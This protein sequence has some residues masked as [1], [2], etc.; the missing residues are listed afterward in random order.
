MAEKSLQAPWP[1]KLQQLRWR[2]VEE[3]DVEGELLGSQLRAEATRQAG[4]GSLFL[5]HRVDWF[6][7]HATRVRDVMEA[8]HWPT[9]GLW[10]SAGW[11]VALSLGYGLTELGES[12]LMNLLSVP[13]VGIV[14]WNV[15]VTI[16]SLFLEWKATPKKPAMPMWLRGVVKRWLPAGGD[17]LAAK[18]IGRFRSMSEPLV[19]LRVSSRARAWLHIAAALLALGTITGMYAK[20]WSK[21]Y[22]AVWESTLLDAPTAKAFLSALHGPTAKI[23]G[24]PLPLENFDAMRAGPGREPHPGDALPWIH[25]YAGTLLLLVLLP[26]LGL[27]AL[28]LWR[29]SQRV[30]V[31][32]H[33]LDWAA[34]AGRLRMT[35]TGGGKAIEVLCYGWRAG[36]EPRERWATVLRERFGGLTRL[37]FNVIAA[38]SEE[39]F[40]AQWTPA[41]PLVVVVFNAASTPEEEVHAALAR[42]LRKRLREHLATARLTVLLDT[43][44]LE[45]RRTKEAVADRLK[46]WEAT[47]EEWVDEAMTTCAENK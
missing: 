40:V 32:W 10:A 14:L 46:L 19:M 37:Q 30:E 42:D 13:L 22:R 18:V 21:E 38:D 33:Q 7:T 16:M 27:A 24:L 41:Q 15:V 31:A 34:Y 36:D 2:A 39:E 43:S 5:Q 45:D 47:L 17:P 11:V 8:M 44:H 20:G 6:E 23:L 29:G 28:A 26:R 25:L 4:D 3:A 9:L 35:I 12:G 1:D